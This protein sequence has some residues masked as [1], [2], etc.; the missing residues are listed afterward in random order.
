MKYVAR[1][2]QTKSK[3]RVVGIVVIIMCAFTFLAGG[4]FYFAKAQQPAQSTSSQQSVE[5]PVDSPTKVEGKYLFSGTVTTARA[6]ENEARTA[7]GVDYNQPFSKFDTFNPAQYDAWAADIECPVTLN[8][9]PYRTQVENT[10]FNCRPEFLPAMSKYITLANVANNHTKDMGQAGYDETVKHLED[11]G[12]QT[13]GNYSP[14]V[15]D[16]ICEVIALPV[17]LTRSDGTAQKA[18]L[19]VAFCAWH[20]FDFSQEPGEIEVMDRYAKVMPV[21]AFMQVGTEYQAQAD[22]KQVA[23]GRQI[24]EHDPAFV[25]GNSPH[26][27]Q[28]TEVHNGKLIVYSTGNFIFDQLDA[29]TNRGL[30]IAVGMSLPYDQN[31]AQ[32]LKLDCRTRSDICLEQA[33]TQKL[34]K[35]EPTYT[36]EAIGSSGG[37][38]HLTQKA[39]ANLQKAIEARANWAQSM[40]QLGQ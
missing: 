8:T 4:I 34:T 21:F 29:E 27:V 35:L 25:I 1:T 16:D 32:W 11:G 37:F 31:V 9:I 12:L 15:T 24:A 17:R 22:S 33:E 3:K 19:P 39:D 6:I 10:V 40:H 18:S 30:S 13:F 20:Y 7:S 5:L 2:P 28:N 26:W 38:R 14:R 36:F 23:I